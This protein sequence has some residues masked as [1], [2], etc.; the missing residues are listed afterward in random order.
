MRASHVHRTCCFALVSTRLHY[1]APP[2]P[3]TTLDMLLCTFLITWS[4]FACH[5]N[6]RLLSDVRDR[7]QNHAF[8]PIDAYHARTF[9]SAPCAHTH[10]PGRP[11][12]YANTIQP[13]PHAINTYT[14]AARIHPLIPKRPLIPCRPILPFLAPPRFPPTIYISDDTRCQLSGKQVKY[15]SKEQDNR[16]EQNRV[17]QLGSGVLTPESPSLASCTLPCSLPPS[18]L[19]PFCSCSLLD[20]L[21]ALAPSV[22]PYCL[23]A[24][25]S[26]LHCYLCCLFVPYSLPFC[27]LA[28]SPL[29][30]PA[31]PCCSLPG[32]LLPARSLPRPPAACLFPP[33]LPVA[34]SLPPSAPCC[35]LVPSLAPCCL[36]AP[37]S[38][39]LLPACSLPG[40]LLPARSS[41]APCCPA[42]S[43]PG[44][45]VP[46]PPPPPPA[47]CCSPLPARSLPHPLRL[48]SCATLANSFPHSKGR[49]CG[50][51]LL[52]MISLIRA[53][54]TQFDLPPWPESQP[55][56]TPTPTPTS[57]G[58]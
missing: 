32:S 34:C 3:P 14:I 4:L 56:L 17:N 1:P 27:L 11:G 12:V 42:C 33:W 46:A 57:R 47:A 6:R 7:N 38:G 18:F 20:S 36:L 19:A 48:D 28:P 5:D 39:P 31:A 41:L 58:N 53:S 54:V 55:H 37:S 45:P 51:F 29:L 23:L 44:F 30:P 49:V 24:P 43:L 26:A 22:A 52:K 50:N 25:R 35:L 10:T 15:A 9:F 40:S 8:N 21:V 2:S 16:A 13:V